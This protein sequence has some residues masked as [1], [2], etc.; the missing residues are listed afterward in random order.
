MLA[1]RLYGIDDIRVEE[2]AK[3][4]IAAD[5]VLVKVKVSAIC[6]TDIRMLT[7][8][9]AGVDEAHPLIPGHEI[10]GDIDEVGDLVKGYKKGMRVAVAPNMG[11][12][13]CDRCIEGNGHLCAD[14]RA[15]GVN[16]DG[17]FAE[18][19]RI[20]AQAV[21][22]GNLAVLPEHVSYTAGALNE[23]LSCVYNGAVLCDPTG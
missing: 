18:Y 19:V 16:T 6:G 4:R 5:E 1:A 12:G 8:G 3:P 13:V 15:L 22:G 10:A 23:P 11:C 9:A 17:G 14:Y 20:P 21:R 2:A 7:S